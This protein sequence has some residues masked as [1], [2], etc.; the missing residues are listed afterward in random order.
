MA[1]TSAYELRNELLWKQIHHNQ[2]ERQLE[3]THIQLHENVFRLL[4]L[5]EK[6]LDVKLTGH[7]IR[8]GN[9]YPLRYAIRYKSP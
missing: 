2:E 7:I 5:A 8:L 9:N 4:K 3:W 6:L 1:D